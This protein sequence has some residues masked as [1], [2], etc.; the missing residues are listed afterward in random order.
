[1]P[2]PPQPVPVSDAVRARKALK[3]VRYFEEL[4][5]EILAALT[6]RMAPRHLDAGQ[7]IHLEGEPAEKVYILEKGWAKSIRT[8]IDGREQA[9]IMLEAGE[10]FGDEAVF[11]GVPYPVTVIA[12]EKVEMWVVQKQ[13]LLEM[14]QRYPSL[15]MVFIRR[16]SER[17]LYYIDLVED[18]GLRNVQARVANTLLKHAELVDGNMVVPRQHWTTLDEMA[19]R[20]GTV[21]DVLSRTL[22]ALEA[23]GILKMGRTKITIFDPKKLLERGRI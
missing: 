14:I 20:L 15:A 23:E 8:A 16:L 19:I 11:L 5:D 22:N 4:P 13:A 17:T 18:L 3:A 2:T 6:Q 7:V 1:M 12:L 9:T 21:R 10:L